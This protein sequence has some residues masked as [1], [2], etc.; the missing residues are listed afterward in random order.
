MFPPVVIKPPPV[1]VPETARLVRV[2]SEVM[3][4]CALP[5]TVAAAPLILP[6]TFPITVPI[7]PP[8]NVV[9]VAVPETS[10]FPVEVIL[11][12][13]NTPTLAVPRTSSIW[14]EVPVESP[15]IICP[16][17]P[18]PATTIT[19]AGLPKAETL[20]EL[21]TLPETPNARLMTTLLRLMTDLD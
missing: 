15:I 10:K 5:V 12:V 21:T 4:G 18:L 7:N 11:L 16:L 8:I 13:V 3:V 19:L 6:T 1:Y 14:L 2:P 9:D 17:P 20:P